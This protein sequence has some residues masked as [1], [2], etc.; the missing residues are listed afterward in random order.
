MFILVLCRTLTSLAE[1]NS[2]GSGRV[3]RVLVCLRADWEWQDVHHDWWQRLQ[4]SDLLTRYRP[5]GIQ[6][7]LPNSGCQ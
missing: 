6:R 2:V 5:K 3:Q 7:N 1:P 4:G